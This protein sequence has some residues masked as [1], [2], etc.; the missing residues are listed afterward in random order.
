M[1]IQEDSKKEKSGGNQKK[2]AINFDI[3]VVFFRIRAAF[4]RNFAV[5]EGILCMLTLS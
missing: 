3:P 1:L 5:A 4:I 2:V